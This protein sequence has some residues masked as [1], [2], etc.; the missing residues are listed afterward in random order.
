MQDQQETLQLQSEKAV[1]LATKKQQLTDANSAFN[2]KVK[3]LDLMVVK[4]QDAQ[5]TQLYANIDEQRE[6]LKDAKK[7]HDHAL[8]E[9]VEE[10]N[11]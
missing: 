4:K 7:E 1:Q 5:N 2:T 9:K 10:L 6:Q 11:F 8:R 3:I